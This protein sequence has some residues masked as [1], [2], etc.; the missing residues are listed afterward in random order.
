VS[1]QGP[2][3]FVTYSGE[4]GGAGRFLAGVVAGL[5][6]PVLVACPPGPVEELCRERGVPVV[7]LRARPLELRGGPRAGL[8]AA[9]ALAGHAREMRRLVRELDPALLFTWGMRSALAAPAA[10][11]G[12]RARP[13]WIARHHDFVP[14]RPI[15]APLRSALRRADAVVVNSRAVSDD[16]R[17]G[18]PVE[19]ILPGV[20]L[21]RFAPGPRAAGGGVLWLGAIVPWKRPDLALE[22]AARASGTTLRL[23]GAPIDAAGERLLEELRARAAR[24]DL[25][26]RVDMPGAVEPSAALATAAVLL[27]T[28]DREPFGIAVAE[29]LASGV[30]VVAAAAGGPAE[31]VDESCGRLFPPG[32]AGAAAACVAAVLADREALAAGARRRAEDLLDLER[33]REEIGKLVA[34]HGRP[35]AQ[36]RQPGAG[37]ALVT[38]THNSAV[39]L[40]ALLRSVERHLPEAQVVVVDSGS[41]DDSAEVARRHGAQTIELANV[42]YGTAANAG[43]GA[44]SRP[45]TVVLN[46]DV[47]LVDASLE[48]LAAPAAAGRIVVPTV[49]LPDGSRQDVAQYEPTSLP[50]AVFAL[51]PPALLPPPLRTLL[52]PWRSRRPRRAGWAVGACIA[53]ATDTL[54]A[55][56]PFDPEIFL[57]AEDLDLGLRAAD[58]GVET[59]FWPSARVLHKRAHSTSRAFGGEPFELLARRRRE[60]I[61]KRRGPARVRLDDLLQAVTFANRLALKRLAG[62]DATRERRLLGALRAARRRG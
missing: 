48:R 31:V 12:L 4:R 45:V 56:G 20:D 10:L 18:K 51:A 62:R 9:A 54:R 16:L 30:P 35:T 21:E 3:L 44:V 60:V 25:S 32:D 39:E 50:L 6:G 26:G 49:V 57:Y 46:P 22:A 59:W 8:T 14:G 33:A 58:A 29:A 37:L 5:P 40:D 11:A 36:P 52:E 34:R 7:L 24:P 23:A 41:S 17:L 13:A 43:I 55:L 15:G 1:S 38:V 53:G 42:G 47:E 2:S 19:V 28:A 27:H 61:A